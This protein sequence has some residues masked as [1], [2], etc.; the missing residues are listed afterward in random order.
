MNRLIS[1]AL[2]ILSVVTAVHAQAEFAPQTLLKPKFTG[3]YSIPPNLDARSAYNLLGARAGINIVYYPSFKAE[4]AVPLRIEGENFFEAMDRYSQQT[5]NFWFAWDNKTVIVAPNTQASRRDLEPLI[6]KIIYLDPNTRDE[7]FANIANTV[8]TGLQ[9]RGVYFS[10]SAKAISIH[11]SASSIA[12]AERMISEMSLQSLPL[13]SSAPLRFAETGTR[14]LSIAEN[15][16]V[17]RVVPATQSHME[18]ML[19]GSVSVDMSQPPAV[20]YEDLALR[21]GM[22]VIIDRAVR[23]IPASRFHVEGLDLINALDLLAI[24]TSTFWLPLNETTIHVM[25]DT[26]QNRRDQD[27]MQVK[28]INLPPMVSSTVLNETINLLRTS[29]SMRGI[30]QDDKHKAVVMRD[31][32]LRVFLAEKTI[33]D[34]TKKFGKTTSVTLSTG[35]GSLYAENGW[36][37]S[38]AANAR[39]QLEVKLRSRTTIRLN[40]TPMATFTE[41]ADLAGLKVSDN[42]LFRQEAELPFNLYNVDILDALDLFAWQTR[43]FWQVVDEHTIRVVPDTQQMRRDLEPRIDKTIVPAD[44]TGATGLLNVLRTTFGLREIFQ[45]DKNAFVIRDTAENVAM[46]EKLVEILGTGEPTK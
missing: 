15:G 20:I 37:L 16:A 31:T 27:R 33:A 9:T 14:F 13:S 29:L 22:N 42:S 1:S 6:F 2:L 24:Q 32:P 44:A 7:A 30:Y 46:A 41:L 11:G 25:Q 23:E 17:R 12:A 36:V 28:I 39:P 35:N 34:L 8:R 40:D 45:N 10:L 43:H 5:E 3:L 26:Q 38:N 18:N 21:A 19:K 4:T